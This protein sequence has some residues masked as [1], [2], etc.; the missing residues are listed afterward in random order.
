MSGNAWV[1]LGP[2]QPA[3]LQ[4]VNKL[5]GTWGKGMNKC[6]PGSVSLSLPGHWLERT[7]V[8]FP[9]SQAPWCP[10]VH[11]LQ[12]CTPCQTCPTPVYSMCRCPHNRWKHRKSRYTNPLL[13]PL[14]LYPQRG[15]KKITEY[16]FN[17]RHSL[18]CKFRICFACVQYVRLCIYSV[19]PKPG[20][21][22]VTY[23]ELDE[24]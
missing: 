22:P 12:L 13:G 20:I 6:A 15:R 24:H 2:G 4:A 18:D 17:P 7:S 5:A 10:S 3:H 8:Q 21:V 23:Q 11:H 14:P 9:V 19:W 1:S 16:F